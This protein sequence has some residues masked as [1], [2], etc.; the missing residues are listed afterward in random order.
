MESL[1]NNDTGVTCNDTGRIHNDASNNSSVFARV[2]VTVRTCF[3][4][5]CLATV[6][7]IHIQTRRQ[8]C[9]N[10]IKRRWYTALY[11]M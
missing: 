6:R 8:Q 10:M 4:G 1:P 3:P 9:E 7:E 2:F 5:H 11:V